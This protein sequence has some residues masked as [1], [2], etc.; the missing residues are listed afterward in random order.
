[1]FLFNSDCSCEFSLVSISI[2]M[3]AKILDAV[4]KQTAFHESDAVVSEFVKQLTKNVSESDQIIQGIN[5]FDMNN[6]L[7]EC[8]F[9]RLTAYWYLNSILPTFRF[10]YIFRPVI[11]A[12]F[13]AATKT[14]SMAGFESSVIAFYSRV[15]YIGYFEE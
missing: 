14:I 13:A 10:R 4:L 5:T 3:Q 9:N 2:S 11:D 12:L 6:I 15:L 8:V 1:M 7:N